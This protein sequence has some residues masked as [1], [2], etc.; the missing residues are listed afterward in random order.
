VR[1]NAISPGP[2]EDTE[3][4]LRLAPTP[5]AEARVKGRVPMR[6]YGTKDEIGAAALFL[7][8]NEARY[9]NGAI[10][11]VDGGSG[12]GDGSGDAL[13]GGIH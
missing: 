13:G 1:V 2:I 9:I 11:P 7:S 3:G 5:E 10:L 12:C 4:M 8:S 6:R